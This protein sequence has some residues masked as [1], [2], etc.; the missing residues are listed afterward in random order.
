MTSRKV[1]LRVGEI[2]KGIPFSNFKVFGEGSQSKGKF[3]VMCLDL[4]NKVIKVA[5]DNKVIQ[6]QNL[7]IDADNADP[8]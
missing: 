2:A 5:Y 7:L 3:R 6:A 1:G 4:W 8:N